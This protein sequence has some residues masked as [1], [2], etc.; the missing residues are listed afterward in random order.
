M[1]EAE[2]RTK[3][4]GN[5]QLIRSRCNN[6]QPC[7]VFPVQRGFHLAPPERAQRA[8]FPHRAPCLVDAGSKSFCRPAMTNCGHG[9]QEAPREMANQAR[10]PTT[11]LGPR[12]SDDARC[13]PPSRII[14]RALRC[15]SAPHGS[16]HCRSRLVAADMM[17]HR[18]L[19]WPMP[20][21]SSSPPVS[22]WPSSRENIVRHRL[23]VDPRPQR[24]GSTR[25][26]VAP[27]PGRT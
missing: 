14:A 3:R 27:R 21:L 6:V 22:G 19:V 15:S 12:W 16:Y 1:R 23:R 2:N 26:R 4:Q 24:D 8:A 9:K 11:A 20:V 17:L 18:A 5:R 25:L 7:R 10:P 13:A